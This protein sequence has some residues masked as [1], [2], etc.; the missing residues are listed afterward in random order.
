M[1]VDWGLIVDHIVKSNTPYPNRLKIYK[2]FLVLNRL[3]IN[4]VEKE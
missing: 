2:M 1:I 3:D 4:I